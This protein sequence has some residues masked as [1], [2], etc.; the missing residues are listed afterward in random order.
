M[1]V[2]LG[3]LEQ[4]D[5]VVGEDLNRFVCNQNFSG[6]RNTQTPKVGFNNNNNNNNNNVFIYVH[7]RSSMAH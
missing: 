1:A 2:A 7:E 6:S 3:F 5:R 4:E